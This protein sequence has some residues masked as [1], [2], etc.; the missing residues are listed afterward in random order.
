MKTYE[1]I[2]KQISDLKI[3]LDRLD[4]SYETDKLT[5]M[6]IRGQIKALEWL[7]GERPAGA[8]HFINGEFLRIWRSEIYRLDGDNW[9]MINRW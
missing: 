3:E 2:M 9:V 5:A 1:E 7:R 4:L 6:A 8:T